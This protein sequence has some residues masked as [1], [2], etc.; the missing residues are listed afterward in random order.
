MKQKWKMPSMH[1][2]DIPYDPKMP[3]SLAADKKGIMFFAK[4]KKKALP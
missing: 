3:F 4:M 1:N 2:F